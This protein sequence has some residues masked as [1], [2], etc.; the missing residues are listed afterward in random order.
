[1]L[2]LSRTEKCLK[3]LAVRKMDDWYSVLGRRGFKKKKK[4]N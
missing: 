4:V 2:I 1:L 3:V